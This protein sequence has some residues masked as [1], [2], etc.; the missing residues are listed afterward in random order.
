M[1]CTSEFRDR[2]AGPP[3]PGVA[4]I[5]EPDVCAR[6]QQPHGSSYEDCSGGDPLFEIVGM[7][8]YYGQGSTSCAESDHTIEVRVRRPDAWKNRAFDNAEQECQ[9]DAAATESKGV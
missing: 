3:S 8:Y 2:D 5:R 6:Q 7:H 4:R 1:S 9:T